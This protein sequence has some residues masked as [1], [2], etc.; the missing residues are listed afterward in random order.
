MSAFSSPVPLM[1]KGFLGFA[2]ALHPRITP[3]AQRG[4]RPALNTEHPLG[5]VLRHSLIR[6]DLVSHCPMMSIMSIRW[7]ESRRL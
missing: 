6:C 3:D 7:A 1:E 5:A 2:R 4:W